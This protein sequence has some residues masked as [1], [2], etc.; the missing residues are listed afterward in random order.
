MAYMSDTVRKLG[1]HANVTR[2]IHLDARLLLLL[3]LLADLALERGHLL[4]LASVR[5]NCQ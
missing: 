4:L 2:C 3:R 5:G 1:F